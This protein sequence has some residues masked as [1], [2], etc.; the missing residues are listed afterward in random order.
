MAHKK[1]QGSSKNGRESHSKRLGV[2]KF[3]GE[4]VLAGNILVRQR[5]TQFHPGLG[6]GLGRDHTLFA[7]RHGVVEFETKRNNRKYIHVQPV[8]ELEEAMDKAVKAAQEEVVEAPKAAKKATKKSEPKAEA[9]KTVKK[10]EKNA[11]PK[12]DDSADD[13]TTLAGVGPKMADK[14]NAAGINS[15]AQLAAMTEDSI[16]ALEAEKGKITTPANWAKW[17]A[18]AKTK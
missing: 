15:F 2:K 5:G 1:G 11:K 7:K 12:A 18:E 14:M 8:A 17:T 13:L 9:P 10:E 3:G 16:A 6:V 4:F